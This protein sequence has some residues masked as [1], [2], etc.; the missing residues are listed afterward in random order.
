MFECGATVE[1]PSSMPFPAF[2]IFCLRSFQAIDS[3]PLGRHAII[4]A[5]HELLFSSR[6]FPQGPGL[7]FSGLV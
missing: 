3:I 7:F 2:S 6:G 4:A 5:V 1:L